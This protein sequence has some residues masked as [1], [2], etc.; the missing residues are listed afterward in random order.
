MAVVHLLRNTVR[1]RRALKAHSMT[2]PMKELRSRKGK[3]S[4][5]RISELGPQESELE[6]D[7]TAKG[8]VRR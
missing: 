2:N 8:R 3:G 1:G 5:L 4:I 7:Y 6:E